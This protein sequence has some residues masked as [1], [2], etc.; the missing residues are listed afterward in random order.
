MDKNSALFPTR[1]SV[2]P[3]IYA[4]S[5]SNPE[6]RGLLKV[7]YTEREPELRI[8]EQYE[9]HPIKTWKLEWT[10]TAMRPDG[11]VFM[12]HELHAWLKKA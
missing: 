2:K 4:Y 7:G 8:A 9:A 6:Y 1:P 5:D 10:D 3:V 12:D 11:S